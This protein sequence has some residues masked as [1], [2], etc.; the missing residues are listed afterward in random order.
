LEVLNLFN[1]ILNKNITYLFLKKRKG[2]PTHSVCSNS[3]LKNIY[4]FKFSSIKDSID[5]HY[6]FYKK[7][8]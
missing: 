2:D 4:K 6:S 8:C 3:R 5:R 1:K 7:N